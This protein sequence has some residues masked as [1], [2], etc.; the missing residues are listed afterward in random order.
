MEREIGNSSQSALRRDGRFHT[1]FKKEIT[2]DI[3]KSKTGFRNST[4][5]GPIKAQRHSRS[6]T[7][8]VTEKKT[9]M[10]MD[11]KLE[12]K[13]K[14]GSRYHTNVGLIKKTKKNTH[15]LISI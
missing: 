14:R 7:N 6:H 10:K 1:Y 12:P 11:S 5:N 9:T 2:T 13:L 4:Q 3:E 8:F 15:F